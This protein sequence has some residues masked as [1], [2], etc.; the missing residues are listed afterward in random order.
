MANGIIETAEEAKEIVETFG[1][2]QDR[3][4]V[5]KS[6]VASCKSLLGSYRVRNPGV[7][8]IESENYVCT[9]KKGQPSLKPLYGVA[10]AT[11]LE[12]VRKD[13]PGC[14]KEVVDTE[15]LRDLCDEEELNRLGYFYTETNYLPT[16]KSSK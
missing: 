11:I 3:Q 13:Y 6:N 5:A 7:K 15:K 10:E 14:V 1:S 9:W 4:A 16:V 2:E 12:N 8:K